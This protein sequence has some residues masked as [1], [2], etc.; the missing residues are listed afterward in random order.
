V[1]VVALIR[2]KCVNIKELTQI[3]KSVK[4]YKTCVF[5]LK[6]PVSD[7]VRKLRILHYPK[8]IVCEYG[9]YYM[10]IISINLLGV[11]NLKTSFPWCDFYKGWRRRG[12][13]GVLQSRWPGPLLF[14]LRHVTQPQY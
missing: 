13:G 11:L 7:A 2:C 9:S 5:A 1:S 8:C 6:F 4:L 14:S 3:S 10:N 12:A